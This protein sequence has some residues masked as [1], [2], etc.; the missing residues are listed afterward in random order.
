MMMLHKRGQV[1]NIIGVIT[2]SILFILSLFIVGKAELDNQMVSGML[3]SAFTSLGAADSMT[4]FAIKLIVP[5]FFIFS[6]LF[7]VF[8][9]KGVIDGY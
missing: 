1:E 6:I 9:I 4:L 7:F 5:A 2:F 8:Y 3:Q